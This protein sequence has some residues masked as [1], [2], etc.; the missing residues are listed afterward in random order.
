MLKPVG[1]RS[2]AVSFPSILRTNDYWRKNYPDLIANAEEKS[3]AKAF[4]YEEKSNP[5][6]IW[7]QEIKPYL[8]DPFKGS[9]ERRALGPGESS[10][11]MG[12][13]AACKALTA[14]KISLNDIDLILVSSMFAKHT[15]EGDAAYLA[16]ELGYNGPAWNINSMCAS[17]MISLHTAWSFIQSG[18]YRNVLVVTSCTYSRF[19]DEKSTLS[20]FVGDGAAAFVV[21]CL[22]QGQGIIGTKI[23]NTHQGCGTFFNEMSQSEDGGVRLLVKTS[24]NAGKLIPSLTKKYLR[25]CCFGVLK[26]TG[27]TIEEIDFFV[28]FNAT[29]WYNNFFVRELGI[30]PQKTI[31]IYSQYTNISTVST[32]ANLYHSAQL[33]K[34]RPGDLVFVYN[35]GFVA[36]S[37]ALVMRWGDVALGPAPAPSQSLTKEVAK[38]G[39]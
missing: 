24:V 2:L 32:L 14:A 20:F 7:M 15:E 16:K 13:D 1:I 19:F 38:V 12:Y 31:D 11:S 3:L 10:I 39:V 36:S 6:D 25:E 33:N 18:T 28:S 21:T 5:D 9:V 29:A 23:V 26:E 4:I 8:S 34:I 35:H 17:A 27:I 30:D 37:I 22:E